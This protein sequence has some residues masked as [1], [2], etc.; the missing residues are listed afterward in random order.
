MAP[1]WTWTFNSQ[2]YSIHNIL[3]PEVQIFVRFTLQLAL[4]EIHGCQKIRN[5]PSDPKLNLNN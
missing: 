5:A 4:S 1:N 3:T 2:K